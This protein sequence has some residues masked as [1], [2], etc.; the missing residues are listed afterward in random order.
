M[1]SLQER[2]ERVFREV[3]DNE[4]L[5]VTPELSQKSLDDWDSFAQVKIVIGLEEE[6]GCKFTTDEVLQATTVGGWTE[7]L[8]QR[9][10]E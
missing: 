9:G 8:T 3:F 2:L 6:F 1:N 5:A 4:R 7:L 10:I